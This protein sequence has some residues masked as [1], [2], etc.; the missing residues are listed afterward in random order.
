MLRWVLL[1][2]FT[3]IVAVAC[4]DS[5]DEQ[6]ATPEQTTSSSAPDTTSDPTTT[7]TAPTTTSEPATTTSPSTTAVATSTTRPMPEGELAF[8]SHVQPVMQSMCAQC[9]TGNGPG[10]AHMRID[11]AADVAANADLIA[12]AVATGEMPPWPASDHGVPLMGALLLADHEVEAIREWALDPAIDID[13]TTPIESAVGVVGL[14]EP[15]MVIEPIGG[16]DGYL[17]EPDQYRCFIYDPRFTETEWLTSYEFI[18][19]QTEIVH[20]AIGYK[21]P[22]SARTAAEALDAESPDQGGWPCFG[23]SRVRDSGIFLGWAPGQGPTHLPAGSGLPMQAGDFIVIQV[24]YHFEIDAPADRSTL[25]IELADDASVESGL[26]P[27][28]IVEFLA[29]AEIP[30]TDDESGPL[31]DRDAAM[32]AAIAKYGDE[33]VLAD[34]ILAICRTSVEDFADMT[35]GIASSSCD[36]PIRERG[37]IVSVLGHQHEI[38][39][40]FR[41]TLKPDTAD[42]LV[43]LDIPEWDFDW[44]YNYYPV[45]QIEVA[46]SDMVRIECTWDRSLRDPNL[47]PAYVLW[48]DGTDD[49][50][51][52]ATIVVREQ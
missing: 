1:V 44:Q 26:D 22:A 34:T 38:G 51:C 2:A 16:Y 24:H 43:L 48:A 42:E 41:M 50:M 52:F 9:H 27:V 21:L 17:Y 45:D 4:G 30:C 5:G 39:S 15:D 18:P 23:G 20:H 19:D 7:T 47:E 46:P 6:S 13:P 25:A 8:S 33:G 14:A 29:P 3:T 28:N 35:D 36:L 37:V 32:A 12:A 40:S 49:E 31:C 10:T 11:T